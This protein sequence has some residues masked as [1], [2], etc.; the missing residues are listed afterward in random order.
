MAKSKEKSVEA[1]FLSSGFLG[2]KKF[3]T[4]VLIKWIYLLGV[5]VIV[6]YSLIVAFKGGVWGVLIGLLSITLGNVGWRVFCEWIILMFSIQETLVDI[7]NK[8]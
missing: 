2:F 7:L 4:P 5:V 8:K 6:I 3:I 1:G